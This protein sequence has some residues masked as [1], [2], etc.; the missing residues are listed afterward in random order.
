MLNR[1]KRAKLDDGAGVVGCTVYPLSL[2]TTNLFRLRYTVS[3]SAA[4]G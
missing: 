2:G 3:L 1:V 4:S